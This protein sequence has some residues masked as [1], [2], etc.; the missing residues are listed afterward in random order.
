[1]TISTACNRIALA[2]TIV[3]ALSHPLTAQTILPKPTIGTPTVIVGPAT[4]TAVSA[5]KAHVLLTWAPVTGATS[6]RIT[7]IENTGDAEVTIAEAAV[8]WFTFEGYNCAAGTGQANC[9]FDD[10]SKTGRVKPLGSAPTSGVIYPHD[11]KS[12][13][14]YT[15]RVWAILPG[16]VVTPPS[17]PATVQVK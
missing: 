17:P 11:V 6:Y 15:Y 2:A 12:G 5:I 1:M 3:A 4:L 9:M 8:S 14:L 7:R 13:K 16:P 10:V